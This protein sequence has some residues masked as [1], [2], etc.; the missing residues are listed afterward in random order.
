MDEMDRWGRQKRDLDGYL[1][2]ISMQEPEMKKIWIVRG[3]VRLL[4]FYERWLSGKEQGRCVSVEVFTG[5]TA[6]YQNCPL[7]FTCVYIY[8]SSICD[9]HFCFEMVREKPA[10]MF[11][12]PFLFDKH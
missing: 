4:A 3:W 1:D 6:G 10:A 2:L 12:I 5:R 11:A 9:V 7:V 8:I